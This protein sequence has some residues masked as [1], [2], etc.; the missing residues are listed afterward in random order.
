[1]DEV[2]SIFCL[3]HSSTRC[4]SPFNRPLTPM[5]S[6]NIFVWA[7]ALSCQ[8]ACTSFAGLFVCRLFL[9]I[10]EGSTTA[11]FLIV[12]SMFYTRKEQTYRVGFWCEL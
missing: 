5:P 3:L 2:R 7:V 6:F 8:A 12:S 10:C 1:M 9:R 11:G 4:S